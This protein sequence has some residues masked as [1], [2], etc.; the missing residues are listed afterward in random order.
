MRLNKWPRS[1][2]TQVALAFIHKGA[3]GEQILR[4]AWIFI[5]ETFFVK[6]FLKM[7]PCIFFTCQSM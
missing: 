2:E 4:I 7:V 3:D 1:Q 6:I 5:V